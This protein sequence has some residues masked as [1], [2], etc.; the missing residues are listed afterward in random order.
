MP[1]SEDDDRLIFPADREALLAFQPPPT[2]HFILTSSLDNITHLRRDVVGLLA[3]YDRDR[4]VFGEKGEAL[5]GGLADLPS[6]P[7]LDRGRLI[8]LWEYDPVTQS[9]VWATFTPQPPELLAAIAKA[10]AFVRDDL[11]DMRSF[12]LDSPESRQ[13]RLAVLRQQ[14]GKER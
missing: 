8:G 3:Q 7:I 11:G 14:A 6:H 1:L 2:P 10:E 9:I 5:I 4:R 13:P 12:S